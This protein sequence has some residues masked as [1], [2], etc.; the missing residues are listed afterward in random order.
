[1]LLAEQECRQ[2]G[3]RTLRLNV[4]GPNVVARRLYESLGYEITSQN[5]AKQLD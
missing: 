1:M 4:F 2:L 3:L 5:M